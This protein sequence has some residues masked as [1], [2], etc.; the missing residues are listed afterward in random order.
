MDPA[1]RAPAQRSV[2][3]ERAFGGWNV[4]RLARIGFHRDTQRAGHGFE[5]GLHDMVAVQT[6]DLIHM[7]RDAAM[8]GK[9][10]KE[11]AHKLG[12]KLT[13]LLG[14]N[15]HIPHQERPRR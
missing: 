2:G 12:I 14:R 5:R 4:A 8:R 1:P 13:D 15:V 6:V 9:G 11:F 10:R 7:Q 3:L